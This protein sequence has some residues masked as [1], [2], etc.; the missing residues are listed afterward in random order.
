MTWSW[1]RV[2]NSDTKT[3]TTDQDYKID[4]TDFGFLEKVSLTD[5]NGNTQELKDVYNTGA[6]SMNATVQRPSGIAVIAYTPGV[7]V[8]FR[9]NTV[10][11]KIYTINLTYQMIS[12]QFGP[13][14]VNSSANSVGGNTTYTGIF[15]PLAFPVGSTATIQG[16]SSPITSCAAASGGN[17]T[18][19]GTFTVASF[20]LGAEATIAGFPSPLNNG[21]FTVVSVTPTTLV[22]ANAFGI[23]QTFAATASGTIVSMNN[24]IY[25]VVSV[26]PTQL[27]LANPS[28]VAEIPPPL[29]GTAINSNWFPIPDQYSDCYNNLFLAEAFQSVSEDAEAAR[30]RQRGVAA[31]LAKAEGL[32]QT[33]INVFRQIWLQRDAETIANTLRVQQGSQARGI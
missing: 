25:L 11:D 14:V 32:T 7:S 3:N 8:T 6:L 13:Y 4:L 33:Q 19:T 30:Y 2:E 20:P 21:V 26:T 24:G 15:T 12:N 1:N 27:V 17:T 23:A 9:F 22:L 10:P 16:V 31:L 29:A 18:Y 28:G 5:P